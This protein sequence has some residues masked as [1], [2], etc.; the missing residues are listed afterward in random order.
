MT[1][2]YPR[3]GQE[4]TWFALLC[5]AL[6]KALQRNVFCVL[7][8]DRLRLACT[9]IAVP[10]EFTNEVLQPVCRAFWFL[11]PE[12][13][14]QN[15][16]LL[17]AST[18]GIPCFAD[19]AKTQAGVLQTRYLEPVPI[20]YQPQTSGTF[21]MTP[22]P[23]RS[24]ILILTTWTLSP[25]NIRSLHVRPTKRRSE[26]SEWK[27]SFQRA[28]THYIQHRGGMVQ[29]SL[30]LAHIVSSV[31]HIFLTHRLNSPKSSYC[32]SVESFTFA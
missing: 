28:E 12:N 25:P 22:F 24:Q 4:R 19:V 10:S 7:K 13:S 5:L 27:F 6:S 11:Y 20:S 18:Y 30:L 26:V 21:L 2:A 23:P 1:S 32:F 15:I 9:K 31:G 14:L 17:K 3:A 16:I 8:H 29:K